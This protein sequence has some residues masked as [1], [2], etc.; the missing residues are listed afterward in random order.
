MPQVHLAAIF[1]TQDYDANDS[2][3]A[4]SRNGGIKIERAM[5]AISTGE[6]FADR[7]GEWLRTF[8][9]KWRDDARSFVLARVA[10]IGIAREAIAA[11][12]AIRWIK[13]R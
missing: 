10:E 11:Y 6:R 2:A 9:A 12:F 13:Q 3:T 7:A 4:I 5:G 1:K 8:L